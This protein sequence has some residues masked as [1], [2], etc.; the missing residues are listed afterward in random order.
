MHA[1]PLLWL[2]DTTRASI[3]YGREI[4]KSGLLPRLEWLF[5]RPR[6]H[7][8]S[9]ISRNSTKAK[10]KGGAR[11]CAQRVLGLE[12]WT[13]KDVGWSQFTVQLKRNQ[14]YHYSALERTRRTQTTLLALHG[15]NMLSEFLPMLLLLPLSLANPLLQSHTARAAAV[16]AITQFRYSGSGCTQGSNSVAVSPTSSGYTV[17]IYTFTDFETSAT[18]NCELHFE[19]SG[20][21][22][23]WQVSLAEVDAV[24]STTGAVQ[25]VGWFWQG[26]WSDDASDTVLSPL[27]ILGMS[28]G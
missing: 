24:G 2:A 27:S 12:A 9:C 20:L 8:A 16:G 3:R 23:G 21:S 18:Q 19:G 14:L 22:A 26:Y 15:A 7:F 6:L 25:A 1:W 17:Q 28:S 10:E 11:P 5:A 13:Y 4:S